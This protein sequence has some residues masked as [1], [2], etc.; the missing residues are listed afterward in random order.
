VDRTKQYL[1]PATRDVI[2]EISM[3]NRRM[4][5]DSSLLEGLLD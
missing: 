4:I 1:I 2:K 5:I 3:G